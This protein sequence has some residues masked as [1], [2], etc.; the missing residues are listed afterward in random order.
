[1][2][3]FVATKNLGKVRELSAIFG[4][5]LDLETYPLYVDPAEGECSYADNAWLKARAL[6]GQLR[7]A[8]ITGGVLGDD[9]GLEVNALGGA[10]GVLSARYAG[11]DATWPQRR[12]HLL[13]EIAGARDR[14]AKFVCALALVLSNGREIA[15]YGEAAG[16]IATSED[17]GF[18]FGYDP[19]FVD[20]GSGLTFARLPESEKNKISHRGRAAAELLAAIARV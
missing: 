3:V 2:K 9:S 11:I 19:I 20:A 8:G 7:S 16:S 15:A 12:A 14:S 6:L 5:D 4:S 13:A 18:G 17:G 10:P 1:L